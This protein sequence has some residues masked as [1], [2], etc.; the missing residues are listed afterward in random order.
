M[1]MD[2]YAALES[3]LRRKRHT[4]PR[5]AIY[6]LYFKRHILEKD[7]VRRLFS[8]CDQLD[9]QKFALLLDGCSDSCPE[10]YGPA[11]CRRL[12]DKRSNRRN[13]RELITVSY[14]Y[15]LA[16]LSPSAPVY[17]A[18]RTSVGLGVFVK[19][20]TNISKG[21][22]PFGGMH[23]YGFALELGPRDD[24]ELVEAG[25][26]SLMRGYRKRYMLIGPLSLLNHSCG[27]PMQ[28]Q[29]SPSPERPPKQV[30]PEEFAG[31]PAVQIV[32]LRSLDLQVGQELTYDYFCGVTGA[33]RGFGSGCRCEGCKL[34]ALC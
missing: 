5:T 8:E 29:L 11:F 24:G 12:K 28:L 30:L 19:R 32:A 33:V 23:T 31:L 1:C 4:I 7:N 34:P 17:V 21:A 15:Y 10:K 22:A 25:Y 14:Q 18:R 2:E 27:A 16:L 26:P 6:W 9:K 20:A 3:I 13:V